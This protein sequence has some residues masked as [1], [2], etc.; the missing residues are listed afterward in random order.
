[1]ARSICFIYSISFVMWQKVH[2]IG[3]RTGVIKSWQS[4]WFAKSKQDNKA[5]F[6]EDVNVRN[7][8]DTYYARKWV[9]KIVI[10]K[11]MQEGEIIL[12]S[13]KPAV[14]LG[15]DGITLKTLEDQL[16]AKFNKVFKVSVKEVRVPE[17]SAKIMAEFVA[18][19]IEGRTPYRRVAK[20]LLDTV[21]QKWALGIKI[22][23]GG[24]LNGADISRAEKFIKGRIPLQTLR[25]DIDYRYTTAMTKYGILGI[26]VWICK[27]EMFN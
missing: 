8:V 12:F 21:M 19:Q 5:L 11:T 22:Q 3:F 17:L 24:R 13:S 1:M 18:S 14:I 26:K 4:E 7:Y 10:R 20:Q 15:K 27:G 16:K 6:I 9:A 2:P 25:A 23:V